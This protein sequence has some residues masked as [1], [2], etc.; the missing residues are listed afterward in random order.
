MMA[1]LT[2]QPG[3]ML[4][5]RTGGFAQRPVALLLAL[6]ILLSGLL[7]ALPAPRAHAQATPATVTVRLT[8]DRVT[9]LDGFEG[10]GAADFFPKVHMNGGA[11][12]TRDPV[13]DDN[14][15]D[16][17]PVGWHFDT[18]VTIDAA[19][20][21]SI[22][23]TIAI[24]DADGGLRFGDDKADITPVTT[25]KTLALNVNLG[26][27]PCAVSGD[28][29]GPCGLPIT[30]IGDADSDNAKITFHVDVLNTPATEDADGD[31]IPSVWEKDGVTINGNFIDLHAMGADPNKPDI[32]LQ[33][34]WMQGAS[35]NQSLFPTALQ[36][37]A[38]AFAA[39][40]Y[41]SPTRSTG[42]NLHVDEG[43]NSVNFGT[44]PTQ[45]LSITLMTNLG[46]LDSNGNYD[47]TAFENIKKT[48]FYP[49]GR[50]PIF[51]Y[52]IA[53][54]LQEPP[55]SGGKQNTSTGISRNDLD[56]AKFNTGASDLII[57]LGGTGGAGIPIQ[58][59]GTLMHELG[60]N[61][62][63]QHGGDENTNYKPNYLS[64]MNY[65]F[66]LVGLDGSGRTKA[67]LD[68][69]RSAL[70]PLDE[71]NL[72]QSNGLGS[73]TA[74][75][76]T[77]TTCTPGTSTT[78]PTLKYFPA[79]GPVDWDCNATTTGIIDFDANGNGSIN[80]I[81]VSQGGGFDNRLTGFNDWAAIT[82]KG[83]LIGGLG[84]GILP[85]VSRPE[86][87]I[88]IVTPP[89]VDAGGPYEVVEGGS[90]VVTATASD[91]EGGP[92]TYAWDL[93]NNGSFETPGQ[94]VTFSAAALSAPSS[95][96]ITVQV[97]DDTNLKAVDEAIVN[98]IYHFSG[99]FQPVDNLPVFN[100][101]KAGS[102]VAVKFSLSGDQGLDIFEAGYPKS[103]V[104]PCD[105]TAP[106]DGV[107]ETVTA[108]SSSLSYDANSDQYNYVWKTDKAWAGTCRQLV[109]KLNDGTSHR[110]NFQFTK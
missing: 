48:N 72:D 20:A 53:A 67:P 98:V 6:T 29:G 81:I 90:V 78:L 3:S 65:G 46:T 51:H 102:A 97:T 2:R 44:A 84:V 92:L 11:E 75:Q 7:G 100:T 66:Q 32:F 80:T 28:V 59:A 37:V 43:P 58:Q 85:A 42:I 50:S 69:S 10:I 4:G 104:I 61:L 101:L 73:A 12:E 109:V 108:G 87:E 34:D 52:V 9:A 79:N 25:R 107:E 83:G 30:A 49:T 23:I 8:I 56:P 33:I 71:A 22:P 40:P 86:P 19:V 63:L 18:D 76:T 26:A 1:L 13:V 5:Q 57:S 93:D 55:P 35:V 45:A 68:Y 41:K 62:G 103:Q 14:D 54:F 82:F 60:H 99:F 89:T 36:R 70:P 24:F 15:V 106:V 96:T 16:P 74:G 95:H 94:S 91:P 88:A 31:G 105:S 21:T 17:A 38:D 27:G 64:V 39:S 110:A 47:W 77:V